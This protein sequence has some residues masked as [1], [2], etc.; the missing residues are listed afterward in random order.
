MARPGRERAKAA[1]A[2]TAGR[3]MANRAGRPGVRILLYHAVG[4]D[5]GA[6]V[7]RYRVPADLF[8][9]Q[10]ALLAR[11]NY[12][13]IGLD[14]VV[15]GL[16]DGSGWPD[17]AVAITFDDGYQSVF[18]NALPLLKRFGFP[19]AVYVVPGY[20]LRGGEPFD[21]LLSSEEP[22]APDELASLASEGWTVGSHSMTHRRLS[23]FEAE[24]AM[25]ELVESRRRLA[26]LVGRPIDHFSFPHG[27]WT[28]ELVAQARR[29]G[30]RSS[31]TSRE[32][33]N[34][35]TDSPWMLKRIEITPWDT[36]TVFRRKLDG[37]YDWLGRLRGPR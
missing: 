2:A 8:E 31:A 20:C 25:H 10:I 13:V 7:S 23:S 36:L 22:M 24:T 3:F 18:R 6:G 11:E 16:E 37:W 4:G 12:P 26:D 27:D 30:Y 5:S 19:A 29:A 14:A 33:A 9:A 35:L 1:I 28:P 32:G 17:R 21:D 15:A 34:R